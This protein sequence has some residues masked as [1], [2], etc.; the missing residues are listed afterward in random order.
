MLVL[1]VVLLVV[2]GKGVYS[3]DIIQVGFISNS[4]SMNSAHSVYALND[5]I[6]VAGYI[7]DSLTIIDVFDKT[8]PTQVG[9]LSNASLNGATSVYVLG[10]YA[11]VAGY[12][13][14][15]LTIID[16]SDKQLQHK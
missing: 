12:F 11:Y 4:S 6:Y 5:Y 13:S 15:S 16:I 9:Y 7:S 3:K 1:V 8:T 2:C 14:D 10:D